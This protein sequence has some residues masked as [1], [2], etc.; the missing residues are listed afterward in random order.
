LADEPGKWES[1]QVDDFWKAWENSDGERQRKAIESQRA[2]PENLNHITAVR[3]SLDQQTAE[4]TAAL[5]KGLPLE[6]LLQSYGLSPDRVT[7]MMPESRFA[8]PELK[9]EQAQPAPS[10]TEEL[11]A[12]LRE[13]AREMTERQQTREPERDR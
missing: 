2:D 4:V 12:K 9:Q 6:R 13:N 7:E 5:E 8:A 10:R 3:R 11:F 1:W